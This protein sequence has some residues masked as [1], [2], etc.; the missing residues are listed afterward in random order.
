MIVTIFSLMFVSGCS[1]VF[2]SNT[3]DLVKAGATDSINSQFNILKYVLDNDYAKDITNLNYTSG[4]MAFIL[5]KTININIH[6]SYV[7]NGVQL[8]ITAPNDK[9][10]F[11]D[12]SNTVVYF[13]DDFS[14]QDATLEALKNVSNSEATFLNLNK[15]TKINGTIK[16][17]NNS[18]NLTVTQ[19]YK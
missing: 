17:I 12:I 5:K 2:V 11:K 8:D 14:V 6:L 1:P 15:T 16:L 4:S 18:I 3:G 19:L 13:V 7:G 10:L 9:A